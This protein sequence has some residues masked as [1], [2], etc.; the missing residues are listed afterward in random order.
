MW[1]Q[2]LNI[3]CINLTAYGMVLVIIMLLS[4]CSRLYGQEN[5]MLSP[6]RTKLAMKGMDTTKLSS[7]EYGKSFLSPHFDIIL[8]KPEM[9][10]NFRLDYT[11]GI[12]VDRSSLH[13]GEYRVGGVI[14]RFDKVN[15]WG[16]G[17][18]ETS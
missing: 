8:K 10:L 4:V 5:P 17:R 7:F 2:K 1:K 11:L 3:C 12:P 15:I 16:R 18:Q 13:K 6:D 9:L 14:H